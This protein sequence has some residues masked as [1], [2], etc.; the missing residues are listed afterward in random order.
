MAA[1]LGGEPRTL[2]LSLFFPFFFFFSSPLVHDGGAKL[3]AE[4]DAMGRHSSGDSASPPLPLPSSPLPF[5]PEDVGR[6][7]RGIH[8]DRGP[9]TAAPA[10]FSGI[11]GSF[12]FPRSSF[13]PFFSFPRAPT[14]PRHNIHLFFFPRGKDRI[15]KTSEPNPPFLFPFSLFFFSLSFPPNPIVG[16]K[17]QD[18]RRSRCFP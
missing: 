9:S 4:N 18:R 1:A 13:F 5:P 2:P 14:R 16:I 11:A 17:L 10:A 12:C 3:E 6:R 8:R 15:I 7:A